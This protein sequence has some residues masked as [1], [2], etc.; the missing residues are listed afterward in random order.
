MKKRLGYIGILS[1]VLL[2][3]SALL[4]MVESSAEGASIT[5]IGDALWYM[6]VTLTTVGYGDLYPVTLWGKLI[7]IIFVL[8]SMGLLGFLLA[9]IISTF[10]SDGVRLLQLKRHRDENWYVFSELNEKTGALIRDIRSHGSG[11]FVCLGENKDTSVEGI[12]N[13]GC[14][15]E[16]VIS[17]KSD[18]SGLHLFFMKDCDND[19]ENYSEYHSSCNRYMSDN[20]LPFHCY[21]L[22]EYVPEVIPV[23]L[24]CF[25]KYENISRLYWNIYPLRADLGYDEKIVIIGSGE[26]AGSILEDALKRNVVKVRQSVEYHLFGDWN[27]FRTEHYR[28]KEYFSVDKKSDSADSIF[29]HEESWMDSRE[30]VEN[31]SRVILCDSDEENNLMILSR[32]RK[33]YAVRNSDMQVHVL[34][35]GKIDD[36]GISTFGSIE[37][38][39]SEEFVLKEKL[40]SMAV[41]MHETYRRENPSAPDWNHL[42]AFKRQSNQAVAD[43]VPV[44]LRILKGSGAGEAYSNYKALPDAEKSELWHLEHERWMRFHIVNNW[45]Y[46]AVRNDDLREHNLLVPFDTLPYEEQ[47]KDAYSWELLSKVE[48]V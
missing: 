31:A 27:T 32:L 6:I 34:Y 35:S 17:L 19:Y 26:Y 7:G 46:A 9:S 20:V 10:H 15:F 33:Y 3:L 40:G 1:V 13:L 36:T 16:K 43:H 45:H 29:Y 41:G 38:I 21:C 42:S 8:S 37:D 5:S 11:Q 22:T 28:L 30:T 4:C 12:L 47:Q 18:K 14:S 44:K 48:K 2:V 25:N 39:Y 23:N 24:V